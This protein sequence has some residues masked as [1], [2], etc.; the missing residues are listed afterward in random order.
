MKL[1]L[2]FFTSICALKVYSQSYLVFDNGTVI[3]IDSKGYVY[4]LGHYAIPQKINLRGARYFF[5]ENKIISTVSEEG[6]LFQKFE[7]LPDKIIGKGQNYFLGAEGFLYIIDKKGTVTIQGGEDFKEAK[8]F[9]GRFFFLPLK[10]NPEE[11][12]INFISD[13]GE[14]KLL[15][16]PTLRSDDIADVGGNYFINSKGELI[17][18]SQNGEIKLNPNIKVG[19]LEKKGGNYFIDSSSNLF[20][21]S[22]NGEVHLP[23]LPY[24]LKTQ[25][26]SKLGANYFLD[27][28]ARL[29]VIDNEGEIHERFIDDQDLRKIRVYGF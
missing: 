16:L 24:G 9:G 18:I 8:F 26:I 12:S 5:E 14:I 4:D 29:F 7:M 28:N 23:E 15:P 19:V 11:I 2:I 3:T 21:I 10:D 25:M 22:S 27:T 1:L 13:E 17:V 6:F 20:T